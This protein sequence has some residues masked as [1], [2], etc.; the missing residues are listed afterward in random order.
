MYRQD[1]TPLTESYR[2]WLIE[3]LKDPKE[4]AGYL[5]AC[6]EDGD[7]DVF[8]LALRDVAEAF[9]G[10]AKLSKKTRLNRENLYRMLSKRGNPELYSLDK[11]LHA[12]GFCLSVQVSKKAA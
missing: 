1:G 3:S 2:D 9:G 10:I 7:P 4:A 12:L 11:L 6:L 5:T 8:L